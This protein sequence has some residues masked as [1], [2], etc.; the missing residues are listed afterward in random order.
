MCL[1]AKYLC[2]RALGIALADQRP[3]LRTR[4]VDSLVSTKNFAFTRNAS[5]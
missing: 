3:I 4:G 1:Y 5:G 2:S